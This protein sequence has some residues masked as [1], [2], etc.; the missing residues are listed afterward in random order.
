M[1]YLEQFQ[2][3]ELQR[4]YEELRPAFREHLFT[5]GL[6]Q[7][8]ALVQGLGALFFPGTDC[9]YEHDLTCLDFYITYAFAR[10][11]GYDADR[12]EASCK[13]KYGTLPPM[14][15]GAAIGIC[16]EQFYHSFPSLRPS[17]D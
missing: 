8:Q 3:Q 11:T 10:L 2:R 13:C 6:E 17:Q 7:A 4:A 14:V 1:T 5:G 9:L 15:F 16:E 12:A